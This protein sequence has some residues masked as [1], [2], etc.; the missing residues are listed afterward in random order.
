M[1]E[2]KTLIPTHPPKSSKRKRVDDEQVQDVSSDSDKESEFLRIL[3]DPVVNTYL[4]TNFLQRYSEQTVG[5]RTV[6]E[7]KTLAV[8]TLQ[9]FRA[10]S[11]ADMS[12]YGGTSGAEN[13]SESFGKRKRERA[14]LSLKWSTS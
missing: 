3:P 4:F 9:S 1:R 11:D 10:V 12:T 8:S 14:N 2:V 5:M 13:T 7:L 6:R